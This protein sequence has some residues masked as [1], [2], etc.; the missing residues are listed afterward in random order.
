[1][2]TLRAG[3]SISHCQHTFQSVGG[4]QINQQSYKASI[5]SKQIRS[6]YSILVVLRILSLNFGSLFYRM[7]RY[8]V[9]GLPIFSPTAQVVLIQSKLSA[10]SYRISQFLRLYY[11]LTRRE[12]EY[13]I[14]STRMGKTEK[15]IE[16]I[17]AMGIAKIT[18][19]MGYSNLESLFAVLC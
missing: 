1:M 14:L 12:S 15:I 16:V 18:L 11:P 2:S 4:I 13:Q 8:F 7:L 6:S 9:L 17:R 3:P 5:L 19:T 10:T